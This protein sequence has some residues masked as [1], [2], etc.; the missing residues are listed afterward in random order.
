MSSDEDMKRLIII[1]I[2]KY[3]VDFEVAGDWAAAAFLADGE[4]TPLIKYLETGEPLTP[5]LRKTLIKVLKEGSREE[6]GTAYNLLPVR[7]D[8]KEGA[9]KDRLSKA[10][11]DGMVG[12]GTQ[13]LIEEYGPGGYD[14]AIHDAAEMTGLNKST[15]RDAHSRMKARAPNK[16]D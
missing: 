10:I 4:L 14:S 11:R 12:V 13:G 2:A 8:G 7:R 6:R 9:P 3:K 5:L 1:L 16:S 15:V